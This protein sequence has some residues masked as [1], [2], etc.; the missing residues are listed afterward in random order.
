MSMFDFEGKK[1]LEWILYSKA[2]V[3][4]LIVLLF[5]ALSAVWGVYEK[6]REAKSNTDAALAEYAEVETRVNALQAEVSELKTDRGVERVI[7]EEFGFAEEGE[8]VVVI[9]GDPPQGEEAALP[10][11]SFLG[12][13]WE[14][15]RNIRFKM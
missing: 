5:F 1:L 9:V 12:G 11:K 7:R 6:Y 13:V 8:G 15:V 14:S 2:A 10:Q 4:A 3:G